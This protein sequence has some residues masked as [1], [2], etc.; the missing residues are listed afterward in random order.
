MQKDSE[1]QL[2]HPVEFRSRETTPAEEKYSAYELEA[3]AV[4]NA[5]K[6]WC[7]YFLEVQFTIAMTL[8]RDD[9]SQRVA[10]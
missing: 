2:F 8:R 9:V 5:I 7:I 3:F 1:D 6:K 10:R 4:V